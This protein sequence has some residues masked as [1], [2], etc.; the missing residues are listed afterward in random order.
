MN[1]ILNLVAG[2]DLSDAEGIPAKVTA[3]LAYKCDAATDACIGIISQGADSGSEVEIVY[4]GEVGI[5]VGDTVTR[6][7][8]AVLGSTGEDCDGGLTSGS[9]RVGL[10]LQA[11]VSGDTVPAYVELPIR[12]EEG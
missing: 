6:G 4:H 5:V 2:E 8:Y 10:F 12:Y 3:G 7:E 11:G 1:R 9:V